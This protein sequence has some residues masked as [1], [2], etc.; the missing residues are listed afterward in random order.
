MATLWLESQKHQDKIQLHI[1]ISYAP[2]TRERV[3]CCNL[4]SYFSFVR[5]LLRAFRFHSVKAAREQEKLSLERNRTYRKRK[6]VQIDSVLHLLQL[7]A[8]SSMCAAF[9]SR[10]RCCRHRRHSRFQSRI[11]QARLQKLNCNETRSDVWYRVW[12]FVIFVKQKT[13]A[14]QFARERILIGAIYIL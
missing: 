10:L 11:W 8:M 14:T 3:H 13:L 5:R 1:Y 7:V 9:R 12:L 2:Y 6:L 4:F